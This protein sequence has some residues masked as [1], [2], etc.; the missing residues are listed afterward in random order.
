MSAE[1]RGMSSVIAATM[2]DG[3]AIIWEDLAPMQTPKLLSSRLAAAAK[4]LRKDRNGNIGLTLA[5]LLVPLIGAVGASLD[6]VR[7]Y[8]IRSK[9]QTD[10]DAALLASVA[11]IGFTQESVLKKRVE[12]WF[13]AQTDLDAT[14]YKLGDIT[15]DSTRL[16]LQATA[17]ATVPTTLMRVLGVD[18][19]DVSVSST[20][21]APEKAYM[22][23]YVVL[24]KS[25]SML[26]ASTAQGQTAVLASPA[27]CAFAC[28]DSEGGTYAYKGKSYNNVYDLSVAM[29]IKLRTDVAVSAVNEVLDLIEKSDPA[30]QR[31]KVG[32]YTIGTDATEVL[33]PTS[34][35]DAA[36]KKLRSADSGLT[37]AT[38]EGGTYFDTS[39]ASLKKMIGS[40]GSGRT[41]AEP[42]KLVLLLSDGVQSERNWVLQTNS[43]TR[44]PTSAADLQTAVTPINSKW[45]DGLKQQSATV[46]V[47]YTEYLPMTWDWG[48]N[49]TVGKTMNSSTFASTWK[50]AIAAGSGTKTRLEYIPTAL[51][52]CASA[53]DLFL[54]AESETDIKEGLSKLFKQ[55]LSKVRLT[56]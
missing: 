10:L 31:I 22:N 39:L 11:R 34:S 27:R 53:K 21:Q 26:L 50:G 3:H 41:A 45:C 37:S 24:D 23:V 32:L 42:K 7:A 33:S 25:A 13:A 36:R 20:V 38:S 48:Y 5:L 1:R 46:G 40:G 49:A 6:Y 54:H 8:N 28:H 52:E 15:I 19:V 2:K 16:D 18:T 56:S 44:F 4:S 43:G 17:S 55:Y 12:Q 35:T 9:M 51:G 30:H 29:G 14:S 47:L